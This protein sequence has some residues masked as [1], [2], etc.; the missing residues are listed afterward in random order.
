MNQLIEK[1]NI[2]IDNIFSQSLTV[3]TEDATQNSLIDVSRAQNGNN[4]ESKCQINN[5]IG[6]N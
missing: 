2:F 5:L 3:N 4:Q 6:N 1:I